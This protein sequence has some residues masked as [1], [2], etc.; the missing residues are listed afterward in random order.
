[1]L[2]ELTHI[3]PTGASTDEPQH[4][5][6]AS[7]PAP[8]PRM[9]RILEVSSVVGATLL[10]AWMAVRVARGVETTAHLFWVTTAVLLGYLLADLLSGVVHW[11]G[12]TLGADNSRWFGAAFAQPFREH[13]VDPRAISHHGFI[14]TNGNT[15]IVSL[16]PLVAAHAWMPAQAGPWFYLAAF[17]VAL[18]LFGIATNQCHKWAH[19]ERPPR[20][21]VLLQRWKLIIDPDHHDRHH[22]APHRSHYCVL[23][24][25]M[26]FVA[27][28]LR[29]FRGLE[30]VV[31]RVRP[32]WLN[33]EAAARVLAPP[34]G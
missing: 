21:V 19:R 17:V 16:P 28:G 7:P 6:P 14:E 25:W 12:D 8:V 22:V 33:E 1:M 26:N 20:A 30:A 24:G 4:A 18:S 3:P 2:P 15:C 9:H 23:S 11:M 27:D 34:A 13:H 31:R 29:M 32:S 10:M 5:A